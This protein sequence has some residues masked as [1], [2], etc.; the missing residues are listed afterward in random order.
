M[1]KLPAKCSEDLSKLATT[2]VEKIFTRHL[3]VED[4]SETV[5]TLYEQVRRTLSR[6][7]IV[8]PSIEDCLTCVEEYVCTRCYERLF[9][10]E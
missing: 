2:T 3:T 9:C 10:P 6:H 1:Q 7:H 4:L 8:T 5:Q